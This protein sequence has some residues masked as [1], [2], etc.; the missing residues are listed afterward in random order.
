MH[1]MRAAVVLFIALIFATPALAD[2]LAAPILNPSDRTVWAYEG[3][4]QVENA[5]DYGQ[6]LDIKRH[7]NVVES[8]PFLGRHPSD[9][10]IF[11]LKAADALG[12]AA[13]TAVLLRL[14]A[15]RPALFIWELATIG[16]QGVGL[17]NNYG[18]GLRVRF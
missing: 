3:L 8:N 2:P 16:S 1:L 11:R 5:I 14:H 7:P 17:I 9:A 6:T 13:I 12:H 15:P 18:L 4:Y 10:A